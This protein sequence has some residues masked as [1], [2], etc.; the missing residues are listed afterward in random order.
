MTAPENNWLRSRAVIGQYRPSKSSSLNSTQCVSNMKGN[1]QFVTE[2]E[3]KKQHKKNKL[4]RL[5]VA[6][7]H[8]V[9]DPPTSSRALSLPPL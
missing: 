7:L 8:L 2:R 1:S 3:R 6:V 4:L 9:S 5:K